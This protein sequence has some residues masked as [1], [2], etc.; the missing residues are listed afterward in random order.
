MRLAVA[1]LTLAT[2]AG[3]QSIAARVSQ[4]PAGV[5]RMQY[6]SRPGTCGDGRDVIGFGRALFARNFQSIG[7]WHTSRCEAGP[8]RVTLFTDAGQ[9]T[10][11]QTQV[12][13]AWPSTSGSVTDLGVVSPA[14]ASAFIFALVA[15]LE[16]SG[17]KDRLLIPAVLADGV[18]PIAPL[19]A[20]ARDENRAISTRRS[21]VQWLGLVG[22]STVVP[23]LTAFARA[24]VDEDGDDKPGK[25]SLGSSAMAALSTLE[26]NVGVPDLIELV[27]SGSMGTRRNAVF[28]LGQN[29]DPRA[30]RKLH[31]VIEDNRED[32]RVRSHAIFAL[33][34]SDAASN[35]EL[36]YLR[37]VY[38]RLPDRQMK[39]QVFQG[40]SQDESVDAGRW[41]LAHVMD[42][43][44]PFALRKS[45]LFWAGQREATP[46][47][48]LVKAYEQIDDTELKEHAIF[49]LSQR[50]DEEATNALLKIARDDKQPGMRSKALFWL[51]QK[52]DPRVKKLIADLILK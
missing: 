8:L 3:A 31:Q 41:L 30:I 32:M 6:D 22:D 48:E 14:E 10:R 7:R 33:S 5:V 21:A 24:D 29:G 36:A 47:S 23:A 45:A 4:A 15:R 27:G 50:D 9:V 26:D 1:F 43:S 18:N 12:G 20:L 39:E 51:A 34:Q 25:K 37:G 28:W 13:G 38:P 40:M 52:D 35:T 19:L 17:G 46:T 2:T 44:E 49:V 11:V 42:S 16:T